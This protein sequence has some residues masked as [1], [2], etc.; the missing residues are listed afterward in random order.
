M[1]ICMLLRL[2]YTLL[3]TPVFGI[4]VCNWIYW[5]LADFFRMTLLH[6]V[7]TS[8]NWERLFALWCAIALSVV[9]VTVYWKWNLPI[10]AAVVFCDL[11]DASRVLCEL[12]C[13]PSF[14]LCIL[15]L[16]WL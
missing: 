2:L 12:C 5:R 3:V 15:H 1:A 14:C 7:W 16:F 11:D 4:H 6:I 9:V 13:E 8:L 10:S